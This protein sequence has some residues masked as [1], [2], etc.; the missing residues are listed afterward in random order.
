[1]RL[2]RSRAAQMLVAGA[3]TG[4]VWPIS[5]A[6][7]EVVSDRILSDVAAQRVGACSVLAI[8]FNIRVQLLSFF[9][10]TSGR[11]LRIRIKPLDGQGLSRDSLRAPDSIPALRSIEYEGDNGA[12]PTLSL[13]FSRDVKFDVASGDKPQ[14]IVV[15][16]S[17]P[18]T[19]AACRAT[20]A[21]QSDEPAT[22]APPRAAHAPSPPP[23]AV[24]R[25]LYVINVMSQATAKV[26]LSAAQRAQLAG[27]TVYQT[28][29]DRDGQTWH[30][31]RA[32]FFESRAE[33][34]LARTRLDKSFPDAWIVAVSPQEREQGVVSRLNGIV[35]PA[36][37]PTAIAPADQSSNVPNPA[38]ARIEAEAEAAIKAGEN[39]RAVQLLTQVLAYPENERTPRALELLGVTRERRGQMAHARAEYEEYLRRYPRGEGAD[40]VNQ[41]LAT[42]L[43]P[44][45]AAPEKLRAATGLVDRRAS[46]TGWR[47]GV[48]GSFSQFYFRDQSSTKF[49]DA[50]R[51][52]LSTNVT[53]AVN[54]NQLLTNADVTVSGGNDRTQLQLRG[55][56]SFTKDFRSGGRDVK[57]LTALYFDFVDRR[58]NTAARIGRQT[59][60]SAGIL[61]RFDG[62]LLGWQAKPRVRFN[63]AAGFPVLSSRQMSILRDRVFYNASVDLGAKRD[64]LQT[65]LYWFDQRSHGLID[66]QAV[67]AEMRY[68]KGRFNSYAIL[69]YDV[70][71]KRLNLG[72][73][74][75]NYTLKDQSSFSLT[76]DYRQSPLLTTTNAIIGQTF[77]GGA[78]SITNIGQLKPF[79]TDPQIYRLALD[80][81]LVSKS[82]TLSYSRSLTRKLQTNLDFTLTDTGGTPGTVL[83]TPGSFPIDPQPATGKE[84]YY[85][86]QLIGSGMMFP[87]D[88]YIVG[89][90]YSNTQ[91]AQ[92]YT[93]DINARIPVTGKLR[94][95]P[96]ARYGVRNDKLIDSRF[97]QFQP[98]LRINYYPVRRSE[99]EIEVG[100]NFSR[101]DSVVLGT[102]TSMTE[103]GVVISAGYRLDF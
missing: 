43:T 63:L 27:L 44:G 94:I 28:D 16:L 66:R 84:Y 74:S 30:R 32:G 53:D 70:H 46:V 68:L 18:A 88:I 9:P 95:S 29:F 61:G 69:D 7:A 93:A 97:R 73:L 17:D 15:S 2:A 65:T 49:V 72:L 21:T 42:L 87:N 57:A 4:L 50:S 55:A 19:S 101:Q 76:A 41:R 39:D 54:L 78:G 75:L 38:A 99:I 47:W 23:V 33:A 64:A 59:R 26:E 14:T 52:P 103:R 71:F 58:M 67:G 40:R 96:R 81:T 36:A 56:G 60:N 20:A 82:L 11:E 91:R 102:K 31:L 98:T 62:A 80:S 24:P 8:N 13:F 12:G 90:R 92:T 89:G 5:I 79:F 100:G 34:E 83:V 1:M 10:Q 6:S 22:P 48:R 25:G 85:G 51:P 86:A 37:L 77:P 35:E 45:T 3:V